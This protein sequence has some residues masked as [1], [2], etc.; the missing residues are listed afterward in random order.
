MV[1]IPAPPP[2]PPAI[3]APAAAPVTPKPVDDP[4]NDLLAAIRL[5]MIVV[6]H[7]FTSSR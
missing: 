7:S 3:A 6:I 1:N 4:R 5:G 2:P